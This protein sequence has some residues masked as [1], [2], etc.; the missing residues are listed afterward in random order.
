MP[1]PLEIWGASPPESSAQGRPRLEKLLGTTKPARRLVTQP[2]GTRP[3]IH[4]KA[5]SP[6]GKSG[7][8]LGFVT[9]PGKFCLDSG[10]LWEGFAQSRMSLAV[11]GAHCFTTFPQQVALQG[12]DSQ[13]VEYVK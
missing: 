6:W 3:H 8:G 4:Q 2:T 13:E 1:A 9:K 11:G 12:H 10:P 5:Q 7:P